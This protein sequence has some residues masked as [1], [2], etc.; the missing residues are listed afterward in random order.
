MAGLFRA[1]MEAAEASQRPGVPEDKR[2]KLLD[3]AIDIFRA[4]L[5]RR[6]ELVRVRLELARAFFLKGEDKLARRHFEH[7]LAGKLPA[8]VALNVT[9]FLKIMRARKRWSLRLG[10]AFLPDTNVGASSAERTILLDTL[11]G[12]LPFTLDNYEAP[13]SGIGISAWVGGEYQYPLAERWRL[14][15]G[16]D[17]S[18]KEYR[19]S[20]F[21]T[22]TLSGHVGPRWLIGRA[23]EASLLLSGI[24][25]WT[26][27]GLEEPSHHDIGLRVEGRHRVD[28][29]TTVNARVSRGTNGATTNAPISTGRSPMSPWAR[30]GWPRRPCASMRQWGGGASGRRSKAGAIPAA[31]CS[32]GPRRCSL[33]ASP[34]AARAGCAG[35]IMRATGSPSPSP[36]RSAAT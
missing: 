13:K 31:G 24:H 9:R 25:H 22:M 21:D 33:G 1:G 17:L 4:M 6:P 16:G 27:S 2:D 12:R 5:V 29:R 23:S 8:A 36:G 20:A 3:E 30:A 34:W 7:V 11:F 26:G 18:R 14:R 15:A 19:E 28:R 32:W 10:A 35:S